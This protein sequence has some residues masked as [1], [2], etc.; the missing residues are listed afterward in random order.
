MVLI[1]LKNHTILGLEPPTCEVLYR[2]SLGLCYG[3]FRV[4]LLSAL[5]KSHLIDLIRHKVAYDM[6]KLLSAFYTPR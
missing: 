1:G 5:H 4:K 2:V 6:V 3:V